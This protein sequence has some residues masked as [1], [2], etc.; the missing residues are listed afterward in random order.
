MPLSTIF[1]LYRGGQFYWWRKSE[2]PEKTTD[3]SQ[4]T[5][6]VV[7]VQ[8]TCDPEDK[9]ICSNKLVPRYYLC[10]ADTTNSAKF[11]GVCRGHDCIV[12]G[13]LQYLSM[14]CFK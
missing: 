3:L 9:D 7:K 11:K 5:L 2:Y 12:V 4:V 10:H 1:Q 8:M 14:G 6:G 13:L